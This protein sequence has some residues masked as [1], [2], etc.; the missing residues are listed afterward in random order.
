MSI[1]VDEY[2]QQVMRI[3]RYTFT[4]TYRHASYRMIVHATLLH[5]TTKLSNL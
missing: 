1:Y 5:N 4:Y 2:V 3:H